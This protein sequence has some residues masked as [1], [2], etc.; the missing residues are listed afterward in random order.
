MT[1]KKNLS[2]KISNEL[3]ISFKTGQ[4]ITNSF[5]NFIKS[6]VELKSVK[7]AGFG[8]FYSHKTPKRMGMNPKTK[9]SYIIQPRKKINFK[10]SNKVRGTLN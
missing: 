3:N 4:H 10:P 6:A 5:I 2:K 8:T 9:E 1:T 7:V